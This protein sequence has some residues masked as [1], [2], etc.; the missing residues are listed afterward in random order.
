MAKNTPPAPSPAEVRGALDDVTSATGVQVDWAP[1]APAEASTELAVAG[2]RIVLPA[3][4]GEQRDLLGIGGFLPTVPRADDRDKLLW[5]MYQDVAADLTPDRGPGSALD[6]RLEN[7]LR[8]D[9]PL[10]AGDVRDAVADAL[11]DRFYSRKEARVLLPL[12]AV[13]PANYAHSTRTGRAARY[14][15]FSGV[16]LPFL[17]WDEQ[18][19]GFDRNLMDRVLAVVEGDGDLT[20]IDELFLDI[21]RNGAADPDA[22]P[23]SERLLSRYGDTVRTD[24]SRAGGAL[25]CPSSCPVQA[26]PRQRPLHRTSPP[27]Q[28]CV[29]DAAHQ[30]APWALDVPS[31]TYQGRA[32]GCRH[33]GRSERRAA[34]GRRLRCSQTGM[35]GGITSGMPDGRRDPVPDTDRPVRANPA[36]R[37]RE[38][39][40]RRP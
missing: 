27:G 5:R 35:H 9:L 8:T 14:R 40:L 12:Q 31:C 28:D 32:A 38:V 17:L 13:L 37:R 24:M 33:R 1:G 18:A 4:W 26:G 3:L 23:E 11:V 15:M 7:R 2:H 21:A 36:P 22:M 19:S 10:P 34:A 29:A 20:R 16:L 6:L 39:E 25:L 30:P